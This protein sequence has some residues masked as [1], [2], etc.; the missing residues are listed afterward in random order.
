MTSTIIPTKDVAALLRKELRAAFPGVKFSVRC[1]TGTAAAWINVTYDDGPTSLQV[2]AITRKFQGRTFNSQ[3]D[4]Y[5]DNGTALIAGDA[6]RAADRSL[7][8]LRRH[9]HHPQLHRRRSPRSTARDPRR[10]QHAPPGALRRA[11]HPQRPQRRSHGRSRGGVQRGGPCLGVPVPLGVG[12]R[13]VRPRA[14]GPHPRRQRRSPTSSHRGG[15]D[16]GPRPLSGRSTTDGITY[17]RPDHLDA[18]TDSTPPR[19]PRTWLPTRR[20]PRSPLRSDDARRRWANRGPAPAA[21]PHRQRAP[22]RVRPRRRRTRRTVGSPGATSSTTPARHRRGAGS[23]TPGREPPF[24]LAQT[25]TWTELRAEGRPRRRR[26]L[27]PGQPEAHPAH[28]RRRPVR[29]DRRRAAPTPR[30]RHHGRVTDR[31]RPGVVDLRPPAGAAA[32]TTPAHLRC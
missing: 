4:S 1:A 28:T 16:R 29:R 17:R 12:S 23:A 25:L 30:P 18:R 6:R 10:Q 2:D 32:P 13:P 27:G 20:R 24:T 5:D 31:G 7:V 19:P 21:R 9:H 14:G 8:L 15:R 26:A 22:R 3:T 11:R